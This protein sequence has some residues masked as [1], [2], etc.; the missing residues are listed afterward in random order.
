MLFS[1]RSIMDTISENLLLFWP[2]V[3]VGVLRPVQQPGSYWDRSSELPLVSPVPAYNLCS[4]CPKEQLLSC[5]LFDS[6]QVC[7]PGARSFCESCYNSTFTNIISDYWTDG[8]PPSPCQ[9]LCQ[10][11]KPIS[12][13]HQHHKDPV[14]YWSPQIF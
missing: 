7:C 13:V 4:K 3:K 12:S 10:S 6:M 5:K 1:W 9:L 8:T 14:E 11:L 2:K